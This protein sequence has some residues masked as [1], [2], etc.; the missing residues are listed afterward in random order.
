[1]LDLACSIARAGFRVVLIHTVDSA[2]ACTCGRGD[3]CPERTRGKHPVARE[4]PKLATDDEQSVRDQFARV[5]FVPNVG[6]ALGPQGCGRYMISIDDDD[7]ARM[8]ALEAEIGDLPHTMSGQSPRGAH[9]FFWLATDTPLDRI[10][11][12]TGIGGVPG[13]DM[14][15]VGGQVVVAGRNA[16]GTYSGLDVSV[17]VADLPAAWT[18]AILAP[19]KLPRSAGTYTPQTLRDDAKAKRRHEVY[20][21]RA[22]AS[23]CQLLSRTGEGQRNTATYTAA[24]RLMPLA[25][26]LHLAAGISFVRD[27]VTR[28]G[29]AAG[30]SES[31]AR[32]AVA[33]AERW[34]VDNGLVR[35]P[36]E[37]PKEV[38][39]AVR[40]KV[41]DPDAVALIEDNGSPAKIAENVAR[42]LAVH[43]RGAPRMN[44]LAHRV[45]WPDG[46]KNTDGDEVKI[47]GWL[48]SQPSAQRVRCGLDAIHLGIIACAE[49][50]PFHPVREYLS[51][52]TWDGTARLETF[53]RDCLGAKDS[54]LVRGYMRCFFI[55]AVARV[56]NPGCQLDTA[57]VLEGAQGARKTSALR[58][59][60]GAQWFGNTTINVRKTPDCFQALEGFWGYELG[61]LDGH[62]KEAGLLKNF[63]S[64]R[65]DTYRP[66]YGKNTVTRAR[67]VAFCAT[68][69]AD[70]YLADETG[71]RRWQCV[72]CTAVDLDRVAKD[73]DQLW[74]EAAHLYAAGTPWWLSRDL[75]AAA[76]HDV[77]SRYQADA[78]E[79]ILPGLLREHHS[80]TSAG[81]L[82]LLGV[83]PGRQGRS[84]SMRVGAALRRLG[85]RRHRVTHDGAQSYEYTRLLTTGRQSA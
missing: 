49:A 22:V 28:A 55:G 75:E 50:R 43:P 7:S 51:G 14:K 32:T 69:N 63:I 6:I 21:D 16:G 84:D 52:L 71:A 2:S 23:E 11:N 46:Q 29:V 12:I 9:L 53:A 76:A 57:L 15:A 3:A 72:P 47:Q 1:M 34:V 45:E 30:L 56:M 78:W 81:A 25:S 64:I 8:T 79:D 60:F 73:R 68:T 40:L 85:W 58:T 38:A 82:V 70:A 62:S 17:P 66:S 26:G 4:W 20:L 13:V 35:V 44:L 42:M 54:P 83:E 37:V 24:C 39:T 27:E 80:V 36:R 77:D 67:Q 74:A 10:K 18:L 41:V 31:E 19:I 65:E 5:K 48:M 61:E 33:S 59:L